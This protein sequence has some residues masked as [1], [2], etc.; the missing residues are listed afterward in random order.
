MRNHDWASRLHEVVA[1]HKYRE[2]AWGEADCCLFA[3]KCVDA[4]TGS[5][6]YREIRGN[7][8]NEESAKA[9]IA[10]FGGLEQAVTHWLGEPTGRATRGDVVLFD[11][12]EGDAVGIC[13]GSEVYAM[14]PKG[15]HRVPRRVILKAWHV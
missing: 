15:L 2:F 4:M 1:D 14:G 8:F 7:Y 6:L 3:A 5:D 13:L 12:G 9:Y 11:G 10:S